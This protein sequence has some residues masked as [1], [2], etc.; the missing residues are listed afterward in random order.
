[1]GGGL[2][3]GFRIAWTVVLYLAGVNAAL[4]CAGAFACFDLRGQGYV[5]HVGVGLTASGF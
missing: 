4:H 3:L 5:F 1:M 2:G